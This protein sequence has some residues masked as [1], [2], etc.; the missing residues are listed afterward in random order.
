MVNKVEEVCERLKSIRKKFQWNK[1]NGKAS[2]EDSLTI[3]KEGIGSDA[4]LLEAVMCFD[5]S[6]FFHLGL[7]YIL[8]IRGKELIDYFFKFFLSNR[9]SLSKEKEYGFIELFAKC[10]KIEIL[11]YVE[12]FLNTEPNPNAFSIF[13][14]GNKY[15]L[16][17][18]MGEMKPEYFGGCMGDLFL[19]IIEKKGDGIYEEGD[20]VFGAGLRGLVRLNG[21]NMRFMAAFLR[22][23]EKSNPSLHLLFKNR[24]EKMKRIEL[25]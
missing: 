8:R 7:E 20:F 11:P 14:F 6:L 1:D 18:L 25:F 5:D 16:I 22:R 4:K 19:R 13:N 2:T 9:E 17:N 10:G 24:I 21:E 15:T 3:L 23:I 12:S